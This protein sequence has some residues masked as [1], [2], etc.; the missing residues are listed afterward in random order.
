MKKN[1]YSYSYPIPKFH[2][3]RSLGLILVSLP[4]T[5]LDV[6]KNALKFHIQATIMYTPFKL[7]TLTAERKATSPGRK[8]KHYVT[9]Q[10]ITSLIFENMVQ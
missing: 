10:E 2:D 5:S 7:Y 9:H 6:R 1:E 8:F 4:M 3:V